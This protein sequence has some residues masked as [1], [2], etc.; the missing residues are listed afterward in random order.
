ME[1]GIVDKAEDNLT[2]AITESTAALNDNRSIQGISIE[3]SVHLCALRVSVV[4][5]FNHGGTEDT[6]SR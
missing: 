3:Y 4:E 6:A 5:K 1:A 2:T